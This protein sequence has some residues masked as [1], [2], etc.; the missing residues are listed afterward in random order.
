MVHA[1][2]A[3]RGEENLF[4]LS[5]HQSIRH[6]RGANCWNQDL[7]WQRRHPSTI[8]EEGLS[9]SF[10]FNPKWSNWHF[11]CS[12]NLKTDGW[13]SIWLVQSILNKQ[14]WHFLQGYSYFK[15]VSEEQSAVQ[16]GASTVPWVEFKTHILL[17]QSLQWYRS[18]FLGQIGKEQVFFWSFYFWLFL[19]QLI[20]KAALQFLN[21]SV[22]TQS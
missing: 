5:F 19:T 3:W 10:A 2:G 21:K 22:C 15:A 6:N 14:S 8:C 1:P 4:A 7:A 17:T 16:G 13:I 11:H 12:N 20:Q 9:W 18:A